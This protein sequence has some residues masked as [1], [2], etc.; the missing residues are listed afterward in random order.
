[1]AL[2]GNKTNDYQ[3]SNEREQRTLSTHTL[4][5]EEAKLG[6]EDETLMGKK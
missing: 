4:F 2:S 5:E 6:K 3:A 1:M